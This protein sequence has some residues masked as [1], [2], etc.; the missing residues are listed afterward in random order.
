MEKQWL[1]LLTSLCFISLPFLFKG[2][3][4]REN[5]VTFF[6]K[7]VIATLID[8]YVVGMKRVAYPV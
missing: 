4:M 2:S 5:L 1:N 3:K 7:G 6:A 8:A